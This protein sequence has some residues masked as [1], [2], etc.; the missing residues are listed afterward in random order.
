MLFPVEAVKMPKIDKPVVF[1]TSLLWSPN[2][3]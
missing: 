3:D 1:D 2:D